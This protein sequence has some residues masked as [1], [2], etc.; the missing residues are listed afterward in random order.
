MWHRADLEERYYLCGVVESTLK[1]ATP[2]SSE[3][4]IPICHSTRHQIADNFQHS[5]VCPSWHCRV[6]V[7]ESVLL[8]HYIFGMISKVN[9]VLSFHGGFFQLTNSTFTLFSY[10][11]QHQKGG[12]TFLLLLWH[13]ILFFTP[14]CLALKEE[15]AK[16]PWFCR[17]DGLVTVENVVGGRTEST[18]CPTVSNRTVA[19]SGF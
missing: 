1:K 5:L 3:R 10:L 14:F 6:R 7:H 18:S 17:S 4:F 12:G 8:Q 13:F 19:L 2:C 16:A 9:R 11:F 15:R